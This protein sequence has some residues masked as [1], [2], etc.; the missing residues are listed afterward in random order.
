MSIVANNIKYLRRLHGLTQEQFAR[1][2]GIKRSL[3]GAYEEARANPN[4]DNLMV[5]ART[6]N[7]TVDNLIKQ[8]LRK[9]RE[10]PS[11]S[12]E[13]T[14]PATVP[15]PAPLVK[16]PEPANEPRPLANVFQQYYTPPS[17][18]RAPAPEQNL[19]PAPTPLPKNIESKTLTFNNIYEPS[20]RPTPA[21]VAEPAP[22]VIQ[23]RIQYIRQSQLTEY[24]EKFQNETFIDQLPLLQFPVLPDGHYRAFEAGED[25]AFAGAYL[26]GS[27]VRNWFDITDGKSYVLMARGLGAVYRRVYNQVKIKGTLLLSSDKAGI[28]TFEIPIKDVLEVWE[29]KA[30]LSTTLPEPTV[31]LTHLQHLTNQM[32]DELDRIKK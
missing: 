28:P 31:S 25:F 12:L 26:I 30:F 13:P 2:I 9:I 23:Q 11:L 16:E 17:V 6:F 19:F 24:A 32:Q 4:L 8:D 22:V 14:S 27:F 10:T 18:P 21:S 15:T 3:V 7:V 5:M 29:I 20:S 1:R